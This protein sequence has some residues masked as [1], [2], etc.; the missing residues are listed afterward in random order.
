MTM[1]QEQYKM[2]RAERTFVLS[3]VCL[4]CTISMAYADAQNNVPQPENFYG[5]IVDD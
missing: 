1:T 3:K 4:R 2:G 5:H